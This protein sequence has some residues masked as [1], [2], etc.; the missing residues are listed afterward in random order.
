MRAAK[1]L[2]IATALLGLVVAATA[3][4]ASAGN[5][6]QVAYNLGSC[7]PTYDYSTPNP[8]PFT[9]ARLKGF[10]T[11]LT[12]FSTWVE[13]DGSTHYYHW[14]GITP[15]WESDLIKR[16]VDP[17]PAHGWKAAQRWIIRWSEMQ[18]HVYDAPFFNLAPCVT[19]AS[20][21][22]TCG[23]TPSG[24]SNRSEIYISDQRYINLV[25]QGMV[26]IIATLRTPAWAETS[27][28][29]KRI[30]Y[31]NIP[32][33]AKWAAYMKALAQRYP[34]AVIE[35][36]NEPNLWAPDTQVPPNPGPGGDKSAIPAADMAEMQITAYN[37]VKAVHSNQLVIGPAI[38]RP[39]PSAA[40]SW[41]AEQYIPALYANGVKG[42]LDGFTLHPYPGVHTAAE[43]DGTDLYSRMFTTT[44][45]A[46][47]TYSDTDTPIWITE[48]GVSTSGPDPVTAANQSAILLAIDD[49]LATNRS[50]VK[51]ELFHTLREAPAPGDTTRD[52]H[53]GY[54]DPS[55]INYGY[56]W[57]LDDQ[58]DPNV[59]PGFV[60]TPKPVY[61]AF[62]AR[63]GNSYSKC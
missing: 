55:N 53:V 11:F 40:A 36:W 57:L 42:K 63:A 41:S 10:H 26:P 62:V 19:P 48:M 23:S 61:C 38:T 32:D 34:R 35:T 59:S 45:N 18:P 2:G 56:G 52:T 39:Y 14:A 6:T 25:D 8:A 17:D 21:P 33:P 29:I 12:E 49:D 54:S 58:W 37:A 1:R 31:N 22:T 9:T 5:C 20:G 50:Y 30:N 28:S 47:Q 46:Q 16:I 4:T 43:L 44:R 13:P 15:A 7:Q 27:E 3:T 60:A 51:A 24:D